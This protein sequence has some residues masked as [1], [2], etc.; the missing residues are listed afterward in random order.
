MLYIYIQVINNEN[1]LD[2]WASQM[3]KFHRNET[4]M[5]YLIIMYIF[6][7]LIAS[8][9][10][11]PSQTFYPPVNLHVFD[12]KPHLTAFCHYATACA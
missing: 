3:R 11:V 7:D 12:Q 5:I 9:M 2:D 10:I 8:Q 6:I 4:I 1:I